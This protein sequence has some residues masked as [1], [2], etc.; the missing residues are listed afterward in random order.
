MVNA[1]DTIK[2]GRLRQR[3]G[4]VS[5]ISKK[6]TVKLDQYGKWAKVMGI[7]K[8]NDTISDIRERDS[9]KK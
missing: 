3:T 5:A 2:A 9:E 6:G 1:V 4:V 8:C 7:L